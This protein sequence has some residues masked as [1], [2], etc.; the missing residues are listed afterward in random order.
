MKLNQ[1]QCMESLRALLA[2]KPVIPIIGAFVIGFAPGS[3][4]QIEYGEITP[5]EHAQTDRS[6]SALSSIQ[7]RISKAK[8]NIASQS[9]ALSE[10]IDAYRSNPSP[11][12]ALRLLEAEAKIANVGSSQAEL[13]ADEAAHAAE[14]AAKLAKQSEVDAKALLP[15]LQSAQDQAAKF[16]GKSTQG[17]NGLR[18]I[19]QQL[20]QRGITNEVMLTRTERARIADILRLT[21]AAE[22]CGRFL[23]M[24]ARINEEVYNHLLDVSSQF[25]E[26]AQRF[27]SMSNS[28]RMHANNF[29]VVANSVGRISGGITLAQKYGG[30]LEAAGDIESSLLEMDEAMSGA[31]AD[32][33][34]DIGVDGLFVKPKPEEEPE[35]RGLFARL[36]RFIGLSE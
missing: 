13:I 3:L 24:D 27:K 35:D 34:S 6:M 5:R 23:E 20:R 17:L 11:E 28:F 30:Q 36:L 4:A 15:G 22:L 7:S 2:L 29:R 9:P 26:K 32:M 19:H 12:N 8:A 33:P 25:E 1:I 14:A 10:A 18:R 21:G 16:Q 31:Y